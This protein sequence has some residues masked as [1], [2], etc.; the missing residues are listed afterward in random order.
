MGEYWIC[1]SAGGCGSLRCCC[2]GCTCRLCLAG[3]RDFPRWTGRR[4]S[5]GNSSWGSGSYRGSYRGCGWFPPCSDIRFSY[6]GGENLQLVKYRQIWI[7]PLALTM[8]NGFE[9]L[10]LPVRFRNNVHVWKLRLE[11]KKMLDMRRSVIYRLGLLQCD[12]FWRWRWLSRSRCSLSM[13]RSWRAWSCSLR[14]FL[15]RCWPRLP[16]V[17]PPVYS[18]SFQT[19]FRINFLRSNLIVDGFGYCWI[20][21]LK[22]KNDYKFAYH[23]DRYIGEILELHLTYHRRLLE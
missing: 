20:I 14:I 5:G 9:N 22:E 23:W 17:R 12:W 8:R 15:L 16:I 19:K 6:L 18:Q 13:R 2:C 11:L 10:A 7:N 3:P 1:G 21:L 4:G